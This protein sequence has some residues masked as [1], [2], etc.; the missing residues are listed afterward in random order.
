[1]A[2]SSLTPEENK[3]KK[4]NLNVVS[5]PD[6]PRRGQIK[7]QIFNVFIKSVVSTVSKAGESIGKF[8]GNGGAGGSASSTPPHSAYN[9]DVS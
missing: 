4:N 6:L 5:F 8:S 1:M 2:T 3:K 9:S 7:A